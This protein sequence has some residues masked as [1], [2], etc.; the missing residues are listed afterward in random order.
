M[1]TRGVRIKCFGALWDGLRALLHWFIAIKNITIAS[2]SSLCEDI[3]KNVALE[4][5]QGLINNITITSVSSLC[6]RRAFSFHT[7]R[8]LK[9]INVLRSVQWIRVLQLAI[10]KWAD[11]V[12]TSR[13]RMANR[14]LIRISQPT[15][16]QCIFGAG[17]SNPPFQMLKEDHWYTLPGQEWFNGKKKKNYRL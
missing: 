5:Q 10:R 8:I 13:S 9:P 4:R 7:D 2:V 12:C 16:Q 6:E 15:N 1:W 11:E 14:K 17:I 3:R